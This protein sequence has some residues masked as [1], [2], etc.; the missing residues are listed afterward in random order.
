MS[1]LAPNC[2][3][4]NGIASSDMARLPSGPHS[5][6]ILQYPGVDGIP[7]T[8]PAPNARPANIQLLEWFR[9]DSDFLLARSQIVW[10]R[11]RLATHTSLKTCCGQSPQQKDPLS[12][13][14]QRQ[15][16]QRRGFRDNKS[17]F[18]AVLSGDF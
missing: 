18:H 9:R 13:L 2:L 11:H 14:H 6:P 15:P 10:W 17:N 1:R 4:S 8:P 3:S 7:I 12:T 5:P 16:P